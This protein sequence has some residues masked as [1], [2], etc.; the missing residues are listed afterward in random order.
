MDSE[1][2][3]PETFTEL[4][5]FVLALVRMEMDI[6]D[7]RARTAQQFRDRYEAEIGK[8]ADELRALFAVNKRGKKLRH[9]KQNA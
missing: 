5:T 8:A 1:F 6:E 7:E 9:M 4:G 2:R 3:M